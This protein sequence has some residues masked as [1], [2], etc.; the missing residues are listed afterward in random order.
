VENYRG[1]VREP[2]QTDNNL[3]CWPAP[4]RR[5][6]KLKLRPVLR[7]RGKLS[8]ALVDSRNVG[9]ENVHQPMMLQRRLVAAP[10]RT[11]RPPDDLLVGRCVAGD[12]T[13][14]RELFESERLRVHALLF[15][16]VGSNAHM[17]DLL[18]DAFLEVFRSLP[19]FRGESSLR[20]WIDR[21]V[22][23]AA[24][25]HFRQ[26]AR[27]PV[28]ES[29]QEPAARG[30]S[31]EERTALREAG[32]RLY[33]QLDRLEAKQRVAFTLFAIENR[34]LRDVAQIMESSLITAKLRVWRARQA[35]EKRAKKDPSLAE[36]LSDPK[37]DRAG[38]R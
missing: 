37:V 34:P 24:Y 12:R 20:T 30:P 23:R 29:L 35:L 5:N 21:C 6:P 31:A 17:D 19:S 14:Q 11:V 16:V 3:P 22:I 13:A 8:G 1:C 10:L 25:A 33:A 2:R 36:F 9:G 28:L 18:Q 15:R 7:H 4:A 38:A 27:V 26:K 32:R